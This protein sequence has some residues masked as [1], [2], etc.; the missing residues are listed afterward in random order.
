MSEPT[1]DI[2]ER[3]QEAAGYIQTILPPHTGFM[4]F[5]FD[6][7]GPGKVGTCEYVSNAQREDVITMLKNFIAASETDWM[8]HSK[9]QI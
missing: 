8:T 4:F 9:Q 6:F 1:N 3:M 5:A 2:R 7:T